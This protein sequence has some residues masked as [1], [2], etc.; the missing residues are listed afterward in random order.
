MFTLIFNILILYMENTIIL[1]KALYLHFF[2]LKDPVLFSGTMRKNLDPFNE[3]SD[4]ELWNALD[5]VRY[6]VLL[7]DIE[8]NCAMVGPRM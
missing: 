7:S 8:M 6:V 3:H 4:L 5:E 1:S 2:F